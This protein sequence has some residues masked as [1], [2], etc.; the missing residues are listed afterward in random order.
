MYIV[1]NERIWHMYLPHELL[2]HQSAPLIKSGSFWCNVG[3]IKPVQ[4]I[5]SWSLWSILLL[6][7]PLWDFTAPSRWVTISLRKVVSKVLALTILIVKNWLFVTTC[8]SLH[9]ECLWAVSKSMNKYFTRREKLHFYSFWSRPLKFVLWS[10]Q[11][12]DLL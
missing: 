2:V 3:K 12:S 8:H 10:W 4:I 6:F 7:L 5:M 1:A 11:T 9:T